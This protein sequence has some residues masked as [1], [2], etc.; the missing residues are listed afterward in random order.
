MNSIVAV[1]NLSKNYGK[2]QVLKNLS[3]TIEPGRVIGLLGENGVGK[4]TLLKILADLYKAG[5][6]QVLINNKPVST[7]THGEVSYMME[8]SNLYSWMKVS[9][10]IDYYADMYPDFDKEKALLLCE[11]LSLNPKELL[12]KLSKGNQERVLLLL[13]ISRRVPLYLLDEP[14]AGLDPGIKRNIIQIILKN[15]NEDASVIIASHLLRDLEEIFDEVFILHDHQLIT[16]NADEIR[17]KRHQ[18][19]EEFYMEVTKNA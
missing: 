15:I 2:K 8:I 11:Q 9:H 6:G 3:F 14:I 5:E 4:S 1:Q 13:T 19:V 12:R 18:S 17:E 16:A 10:A 7:L